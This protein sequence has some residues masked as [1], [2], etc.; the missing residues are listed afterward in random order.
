MTKEVLNHLCE[1]Y[2]FGALYQTDFISLM[3][4]R[5]SKQGEFA[6]KMWEWYENWCREQ[7]KLENENICYGRDYV[8]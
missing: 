8:K 5:K 6:D 1:A 4:I 2:L 7:R 3:K